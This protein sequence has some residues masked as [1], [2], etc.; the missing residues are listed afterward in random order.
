[1]RRRFENARDKSA[2][3]P[4]SDSPGLGLCPHCKSATKVREDRL[5]AH[6]RKRAKLT[7]TT[8]F[9]DLRHTYATLLITKNV[10]LRRTSTAGSTCSGR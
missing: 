8:R 6:M 7:E 5:E 2:K 9:Q 1:M 4:T 3:R 10:T